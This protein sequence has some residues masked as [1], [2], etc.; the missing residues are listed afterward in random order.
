M[1]RL[2]ELRERN[3]Y[4]DPLSRGKCYSVAL[5][6]DHSMLLMGV[7]QCQ[8]RQIVILKSEWLRKGMLED[9]RTARM[10]PR[11]SWAGLTPRKGP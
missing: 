3:R 4:A 1:V 9:G 10:F 11:L 5:S 8:C 7:V 2:P 6:V